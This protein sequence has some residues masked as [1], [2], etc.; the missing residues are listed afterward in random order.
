MIYKIWKKEFEKSRKT[1]IKRTNNF[2]LMKNI[3]SS[4]NP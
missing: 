2:S 1:K 3:S 4:K